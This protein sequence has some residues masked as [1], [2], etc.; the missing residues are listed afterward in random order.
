MKHHRI[1][2]IFFYL[3]ILAILTLSFFIF[4]PFFSV[5][6]LALVFA[7]LFDPVHKKILSVFHNRHALSA[8]FSVLIVFFVIVGPI[9]F[10]G[11]LLFQEATNLY[12][13]ILS[14]GGNAHITNSIV[15]FQSGVAQYFPQANVSLLEGDAQTYLES[16]L[17]WFLKHFSIVFSGAVNIA[18][19]LFLMLLALFYF[20]KDGKKLVETLIDL[21]PLEDVNDK[22]IIGRIVVAVNSVVRGN[23]VIGVIQGLLTGIGFAIF[24]VPSPVIWGTVAAVTS[25]MPTIG[26]SIVLI[27]GILF[28]FFSSGPLFGLGLLLWGALAVGLIDNFLGPTLINRDIHIHPFLIL[29]SVFG[30]LSF[31][32]PIG[33]I[34]GPVILSMLFSLFDIYPVVVHGAKE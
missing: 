3:V 25:L 22:K 29:L 10:L 7:I 28:V 5:L 8:F 31:F 11:T 1:Q 13:S 20:F 27:P 6:F 23:L 33:F 24:G 34:A 9:S 14:D 15:A 18:F 2:L 17:S 32:G 16:G 26:T 19:S 21:S 30:G 4:L 12:T